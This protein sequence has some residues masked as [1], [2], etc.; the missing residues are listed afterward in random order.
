MPN[1]L[2][3]PDLQDPV[4]RLDPALLEDV[5]EPPPAEDRLRDEDEAE[6]EGQTWLETM[7]ATAAENGTDRPIDQLIDEELRGRVPRHRKN[8]DPPVADRGAGGRR[9]V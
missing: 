1:R 3:K 8:G 2:P 7:E 9:G 4:Q 6:V 5:F